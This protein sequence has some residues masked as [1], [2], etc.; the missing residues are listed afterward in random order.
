MDPV[1]EAIADGSDLLVFGE[2]CNGVGWLGV[3]R[4]DGPDLLEMAAEPIPGRTTER[5]GSLARSGNCYV[6][7]CLFE[8]E[9]GKIYNTAVLLDP[10]GRPG[11]LRCACGRSWHG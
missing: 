10:H 2:D 6:S 9:D 8:L 1:Q 3:D 11:G 5:L 7:G 4:F